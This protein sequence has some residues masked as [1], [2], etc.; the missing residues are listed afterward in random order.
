M[1]EKVGVISV[2]EKGS[3]KQP[4]LDSL[5]QYG[6]T[7]H[8]NTISQLRGNFTPGTRIE[9]QLNA[10][11]ALT[12]DDALNKDYTY[13]TIAR[14]G[15]R[16]RRHGVAQREAIYVSDHYTGDIAYDARLREQEVRKALRSMRAEIAY[17]PDRL[18]EDHRRIFEGVVG[19]FL[20]DMSKLPPSM[21][22]A[23]SKRVEAAWAG[24]I[25]NFYRALYQQ[26]GSRAIGH[27]VP[28]EMPFLRFFY[29]DRVATGSSLSQFDS[30]V[31]AST[32]SDDSLETIV[33]DTR[34][35]TGVDVDRSVLEVHRNFLLYGKPASPYWTTAT[36]PKT[37]EI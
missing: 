16:V 4:V 25:P 23:L 28:Y 20:E 26:N 24:N 15:V 37:A 35:R 10:A 12:D 33:E 19:K 31:L 36:Y 34:K 27:W 9:H 7:I 3:P 29:Q 21:Q 6:I 13:L 8:P 1:P 2:G 18:T 22:S 14:S 30:L 5:A 32:F 17:D 11:K